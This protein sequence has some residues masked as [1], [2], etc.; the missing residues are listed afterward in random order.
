MP[1][2]T[3][4][5]VRRWSSDLGQLLLGGIDANSAAILEQERIAVTHPDSALQVEQELGAPRSDKGDAA[6]MALIEIEGH[7]VFD[8]TLFG[9]SPLASRCS[10]HAP[11]RQKRK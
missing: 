1:R 9:A 11:A 7:L 5:R 2:N 10:Y 4:E 3:H 8:E 6:P